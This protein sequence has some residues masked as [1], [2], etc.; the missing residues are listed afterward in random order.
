MGLCSEMSNFVPDQQDR[1]PTGKLAYCSHR[2]ND[3]VDPSQYASDPFTRAHTVLGY[4]GGLRGAQVGDSCTCLNAQPTSGPRNVQKYDNN[5]AA[6]VRPT[7]TKELPTSFPALSSPSENIVDQTPMVLS[8]EIWA[9]SWSHP[10]Q[11]EPLQTPVF[12]RSITDPSVSSLPTAAAPTTNSP[13]VHVHLDM[14][15]SSGLDTNAP[16]SAAPTNMPASRAEDATWVTLGPDAG[17]P[18]YMHCPVT[19][20]KG[21]ST[22]DSRRATPNQANTSTRIPHKVVERRYRDKMKDQMELLAAKVPAISLNYPSLGEVEDAPKSL[23]GPPKAVI[24]AGAVRYIERLEREHDEAQVL[25]ER[26]Q[27]QIVGLQ[28]LVKCDDCSLLR[29]LESVGTQRAI[30]GGAA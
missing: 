12:R 5:L 2:V 8:S 23:R 25:I 9:N 10:S 3:L 15:S 18:C 17:Q 30:Q 13:A 11:T 7:P 29:Y 26:L 4:G 21:T 27:E 6:D 20:P 22:V 19:V 14:N 24:I 1:L 28:K 16:I